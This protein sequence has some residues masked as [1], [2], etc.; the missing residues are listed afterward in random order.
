MK[1]GA[2]VCDPFLV[3]DFNL[4][5]IHTGNSVYNIINDISP[6]FNDTMRLCKWRHKIDFCSAY[7]VP[8]LT[9]EGVCFTFNALNSRDIYTE[10]YEFI[11]ST[12]F[13]YFIVIY[14]FY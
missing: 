4:E 6:T 3:E 8:I 5:Q 1:A 10:K 11:F 9:E 12:D 13:F 14:L 7:F 2:H